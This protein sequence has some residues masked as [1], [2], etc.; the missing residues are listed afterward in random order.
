MKLHIYYLIS[1]SGAGDALMCRGRAAQTKTTSVRH[2][3]NAYIEPVIW[4]D[5]Q[6][7]AGVVYVWGK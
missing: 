1:A 2:V 3:T 7:N 5:K 6:R 4:R